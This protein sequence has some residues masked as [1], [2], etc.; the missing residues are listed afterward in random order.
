MAG[1]SALVK[2]RNTEEAKQEHNAIQTSDTVQ[3]DLGVQSL[4]S[5]G[6]EGNDEETTRLDVGGKKQSVDNLGDY[7]AVELNQTHESNE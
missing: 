3:S 7:K 6:S 5:V 4:D 2:D 1:L